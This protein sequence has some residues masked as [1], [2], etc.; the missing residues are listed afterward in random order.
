[1]EFI[2]NTFYS[3]RRTKPFVLAN[4]CV[5][6]GNADYEVGDMVVFFYGSLLPAIVRPT[7]SHYRLVGPAVIKGIPDHLWPLS[8]SVEQGDVQ[9]ID[10]I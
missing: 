7:G 6:I 10:L 4:G 3:S 8:N 5:G 2:G 9:L 1:L